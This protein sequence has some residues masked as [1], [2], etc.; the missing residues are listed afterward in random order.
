VALTLAGC[1]GGD[2]GDDGT[3]TSAVESTAS[4]EESPTPSVMTSSPVDGA[5]TEIAAEG[6]TPGAATPTPAIVVS[7]PPLVIPTPRPSAATPVGEGAPAT[8]VVATASIVT[9]D[10]TGG[11]SADTV[12]GGTPVADGTP[13]AVAVTV[14][15]CDVPEFP[16]YLGQEPAQVT[17]I[18]VNFRAGPG[19]DCETV[20]QPVPAGVTVE[21]LS[22]PVDREGDDFTWVAVSLDG[23]QAWVAIDFLEPAP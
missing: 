17:T 16:E 2:D 18:D 14:D 4:I 12:P 19:T 9:G 3:A 15:S 6:G 1:G 8:P 13:V 22:N 23:E 11:P 5:S 10:G 7:A 20:G 21:I